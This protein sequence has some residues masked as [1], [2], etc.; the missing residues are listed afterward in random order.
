MSSIHPLNKSTLKNFI[1]SGSRCKYISGLY[2]VATPIGN[3]EDIS[4]RAL[5]VLNNV[6]LIACEDT[7]VTKKLLQPY[8][9]QKKLVSCHE[10]NKQK[11]VPQLV[12]KIK[13]GQS[14]AYVTDAGMPLISDPGYELIQACRQAY[15]YVTVIPGPSAPLTALLLSGLPCDAFYFGSFLPA[16]SKA[17]Q[18]KLKELENLNATLIFFESPRRLKA[19]L[20][21][22]RSL[23]PGRIVSVARELTKVFEEIKRGPVEEIFSYYDDHPPKGEIV[24]LLSPFNTKPQEDKQIE[25]HLRSLMKTLTLK[26]AVTVIAQ[27]TGLPKKQ[28]YKIG[29]QI[30]HDPKKTKK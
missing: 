28:I 26:D 15:L 5:Y 2:L 20:K 3:L 23:F 7:R 14:I 1:D 8:G 4:L 12:D 25:P 30:R 6:D 13:A 11:T 24:L 10:H 16:K 19:T 29:L 18:Q 21:D 27:T 9:I 17:R 22:I